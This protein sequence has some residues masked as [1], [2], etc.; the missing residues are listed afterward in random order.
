MH[1]ELKI[2]LLSYAGITQTGSKGQA[3][4]T[5]SAFAPLV[6]YLIIKLTKLYAIHS[7]E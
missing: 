5:F 4:E 3:I 1:L 7:K 2:Q 6:I